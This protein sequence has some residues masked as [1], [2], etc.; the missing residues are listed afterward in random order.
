LPPAGSAPEAQHFAAAFQAAHGAAPTFI[1]AHAFDAVRLIRILAARGAT[2]RA[3]LVSALGA[4]DV[5]G[6][7][8]PLRFDAQ[9]ELTEPPALVTIDAGA[10]RPVR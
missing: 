6:V 5:M 3:S 4:S 8:G 7:T 1:E 9:R 10:F 2:L